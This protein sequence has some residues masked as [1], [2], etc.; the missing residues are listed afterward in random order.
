MRM[1]ATD[2]PAIKKS[3]RGGANSSTVY[4]RSNV[5]SIVETPDTYSSLND[6]VSRTYDTRSCVSRIGRGV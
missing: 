2:W 6:N 3:P 1:A 4:R 5:S